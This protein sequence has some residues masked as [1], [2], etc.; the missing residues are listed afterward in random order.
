MNS[1]SLQLREDIESKISSAVGKDPETHNELIDSARQDLLKLS[2]LLDG[3]SNIDSLMNS[4]NEYVRFIVSFWTLDNMTGECK[5]AAIAQLK[6]MY[7]DN[8]MIEYIFRHH[9]ISYDPK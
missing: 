3:K 9:G 8:F 5:A 2:K 1:P 7:H 6:A 4:Q